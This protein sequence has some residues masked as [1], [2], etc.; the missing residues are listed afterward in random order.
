MLNDIKVATCF[1]ILGT[2]IED[3]PARSAD[4]AKSGYADNDK[5]VI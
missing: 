4:N 5:L 1:K 3:L 2:V